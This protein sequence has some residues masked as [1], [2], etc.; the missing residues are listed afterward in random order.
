MD[1]KT[2]GIIMDGNRRFARERKLPLLEGHRA[3]KEKLKEV[4]RWAKDAGVPNLIVYAFSNENWSR[5]REEVDYLMEIIRLMF[6][7]E[8]NDFKKEKVRLRF[9]GERERFSKDIQEILNNVENE[10]KDF[11]DFTLWVA[12]SYGGRQEIMSTVNKIL[13][14][15]GEKITEGDFSKN[16]FTADMPDPD[17]I[18]R[19]SGEKRLSGFLPWQSVYAELFFIDTL[20]PALTKKEFLGILDEYDTRQR[21]FGK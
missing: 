19:T 21:R 12:L 18:I 8:L 5:A 6:K 4:M 20:W 11:S 10:T 17:I 7:H 15:G 2:I 3:G 9:V 1:I 14:A 16:L 13:A